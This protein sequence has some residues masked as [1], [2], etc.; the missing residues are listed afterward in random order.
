[1]ITVTH[2]SLQDG[3]IF[4]AELEVA[5]CISFLRTVE[6]KV[7]LTKLNQCHRAAQWR[8]IIYPKTLMRC[9]YNCFHPQNMHFSL[10][11]NVIKMS[12]IAT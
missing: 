5:R 1:M 7:L 4:S 6:F 11:V 9:P 12:W 10:Y 2:N 3:L 8:K